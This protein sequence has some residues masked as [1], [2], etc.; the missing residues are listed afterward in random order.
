MTNRIEVVSAAI[1]RRGEDGIKR[2]LL[3]QRQPGSSYPYLYC[4][5][6]G[7]ID[8]GEAPAHALARELRE[9]IGLSAYHVLKLFLDDP[10]PIYEH[11][12]ISSTTGKPARVRCYAFHAPSAFKAQALDGLIGVGWFTREQLIAVDLAPADAA[13]REVLRD[14]V[15]AA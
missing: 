5:P 8:L 1:I 11:E 10:K 3:G 9:E 7:K 4:S 2:L 15:Y 12:M 14:L 13:N 6:G